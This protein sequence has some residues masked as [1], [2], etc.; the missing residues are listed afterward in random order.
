MPWTGAAKAGGRQH[1][2][3]LEK[4]ILES[5]CKIITVCSSHCLSFCA[6]SK[7]SGRS[8]RRDGP[9][10]GVCCGNHPCFP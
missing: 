9:L 7:P 6:C 4:K 3:G 1:H 5:H 8:F 2:Q 10:V